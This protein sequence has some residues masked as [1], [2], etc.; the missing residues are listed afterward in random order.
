MHVAKP[1]DWLTRWTRDSV[2]SP[3]LAVIPAVQPCIEAGVDWPLELYYERYST[4]LSAGETNINF[5]D[6]WSGVTTDS[7]HHQRVKYI[8]VEPGGSVALAIFVR[9][10]GVDVARLYN[11]AAAS[12]HY[13]PISDIGSVYT[14]TDVTSLHFQF[15]GASGAEN[16]R[17]DLQWW[18][19]RS[20]DPLNVKV[21]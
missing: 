3:Q 10:N 19:R 20:S 18:G 12:I 14:V 15:S 16:A 13:P 17:I 21:Y 6:D 1:F 4:T 8:A 9:Q 5:P 2:Q 7:L 11:G